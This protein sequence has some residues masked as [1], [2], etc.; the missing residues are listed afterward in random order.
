MIAL[1]RYKSH[2][3]QKPWYN[4][5]MYKVSEKHELRTSSYINLTGAL[6]MSLSQKM[7]ANAFTVLMNAQ[8]QLSSRTNLPEVVSE[9][10]NAKQRLR[11]DVIEFLRERECK[12]R[13]SDVP[14]LGNSLTQAITNALWTI[15]GHHEVFASQGF[16]LP[17]FAPRFMKYNCPELSKHRKRQAQNMSRSELNLVSSHIF[18]CLQAHYWSDEPWSAFKGEVEQLAQSIHRYSEYLQRSCKKSCFNQSRLTPVRQV[19]ENVSFQF[20]PQCRSLQPILNELSMKL[21]ECADYEYLAVEDFSPNSSISKYQYTQC[22]KNH[23]F[24]FPAVLVTYAHGNNLGNLNFVWKVP[25]C[26]E[27]AFSASQSVIL[28]LQ[29]KIPTFHTRAMR[30]Q[31]FERFGRL[32]PSVKPAVL[33]HVYKTLTGMLHVC[34]CTVH[35]QIECVLI[36]FLQSSIVYSTTLCINVHSHTCTSLCR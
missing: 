11:N 20:L 4:Y 3:L 32:M 1:G 9:P 24:P 33:R 35:V 18:D 2:T 14:T 12:W 19:S 8:S 17:S 25:S 26:D 15:D 29:E 21:Q 13:A 36:P 34:L 6:Q 5:Y 22:M 28:K 27:S 30:K 16:S 31:M 10:R 7:Q 23:G